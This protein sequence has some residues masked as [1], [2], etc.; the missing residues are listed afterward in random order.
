M[1]AMSTGRLERRRADSLNAGMTMVSDG[2][3][4][5]GS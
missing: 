3:V 4:T 1:W 5:L 2:G